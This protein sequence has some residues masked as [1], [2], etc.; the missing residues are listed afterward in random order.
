MQAGQKSLLH[1]TIDASS[2]NMI[3]NSINM[4][5]NH[6]K[7]IRNAH[8]IAPDFH[9]PALAVFSFITVCQVG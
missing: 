8:Q 4:I 6:I 7:M 3:R 1:T 9:F 5:R 2:A